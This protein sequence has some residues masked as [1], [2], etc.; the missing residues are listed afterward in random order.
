MEAGAGRRGIPSL[1]KPPAARADESGGATSPQ[2]EHIASDITQLVGWTPLVE[3]KR[4]AQKDNVDA[5]V[6]GKLECYQPLC[7]VKDRSALRM[8]ED[9]EERGL[10]SPGA[11]TLV[12][13][14]SGNMGIALAYIA[15]ARGYR[16]VAVMPAEYSLD[17]QILLRYLGADLV[18]TGKE[19]KILR[20]ASR[21]SSTSWSSS[22][23]KYP[24]RM[25]L[26]SSQTR[27]TLKRTLDGL[28]VP[29][30][31]QEHLIS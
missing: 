31:A 26:T 4:I 22:G 30:F 2:Q 25:F 24:T 3:L 1:L 15:L 23:K 21:D 12:E 19:V 5:R 20:L 17:K 7:S 18:L 27:R 10:I 13:P 8:I 14:T 28:V 9:A 11:T 29:I 6:V 16:F